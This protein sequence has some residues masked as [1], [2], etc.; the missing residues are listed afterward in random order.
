[1]EVWRA[2]Q[3]GVPVIIVNPGVIIG[4]GFWNS[5]SGFLFKR[6]FKGLKYYFPKVTGF[7]GVNDVV[8]A[9]QQL[10]TSPV[11]NEEF[12]LVSENLSFQ[13][14][15]KK[16]ANSIDKPAPTKQLKPWTIHFGWM[17]E[18]ISG[19]FTDNERHLTRRSAESLFE[20]SYYTIEKIK[21]E[22]SFEFE[23]LDGVIWST[24]KLFK[25]DLE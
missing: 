13:E 21:Q 22:I 5:G 2:S 19:L 23:N 20:E 24:G 12:I 8:K 18:K 10:M 11:Q 17:L 1:M 9:M 6:V 25:K 14:L 3:E 16:V 7:V 15:L 4:P